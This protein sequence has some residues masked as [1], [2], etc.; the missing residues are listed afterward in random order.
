MRPK[1]RDSEGIRSSLHGPVRPLMYSATE[2]RQSKISF[3]GR[4]LF[5]AAPKVVWWSTPSRCYA[6]A[7]PQIRRCERSD[8]RARR[9]DTNSESN[10]R[11]RRDPKSRFVAGRHMAREASLQYSAQLEW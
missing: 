3:R 9:S 10:S 4:L 1:I 11:H 5:H 8:I 7:N 2:S 6:E